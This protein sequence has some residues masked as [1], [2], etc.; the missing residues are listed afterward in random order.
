MT[1]RP[2]KPIDWKKTSFEGNR[3]EQ[4]RQ[5]RSMT[6]RQRLEA[7]SDL[8]ELAERLRSMP[9]HQKPRRT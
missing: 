5:A 4:L 8:T 3:R 7:C 9:R 6:L 2:S 1:I